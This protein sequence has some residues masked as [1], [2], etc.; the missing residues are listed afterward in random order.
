MLED[1][2]FLEM[3]VPQKSSLSVKLTVPIDQEINHTAGQPTPQ[4]V[5][6]TDTIVSSLDFLQEPGWWAGRCISEDSV[7][8]AILCFF[9]L[10]RK[11]LTRVPIFLKTFGI[12]FTFHSPTS[13]LN[14]HPWQLHPGPPLDACLPF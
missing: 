1:I 2:E 14:R 8:K 3:G 4:P 12:D 10:L 5:Q 6:T 13:Q 11:S 9:F 7:T